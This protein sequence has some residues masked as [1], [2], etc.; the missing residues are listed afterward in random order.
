MLTLTA[1]GDDVGLTR[2]RTR[3]LGDL[4]GLIW[5]DFAPVVQGRLAKVEGGQ[6]PLCAT[7]F[8]CALGQIRDTLDAWLAD[9]DERND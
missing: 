4:L 7:D 2:A 8:H 9:G 1:P 3:P 6:G 5:R